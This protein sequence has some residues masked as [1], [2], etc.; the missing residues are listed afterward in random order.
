MLYVI[1]VQPL[2]LHHKLAFSVFNVVTVETKVRKSRQLWTGL[3]RV[4]KSHSGVSSIFSV[5]GSNICDTECVEE[6][7][8]SKA[9]WGVQI[10]V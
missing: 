4:C 8:R 7:G 1:L 10:G 3:Q 9:I 6:M 2:I 5:K